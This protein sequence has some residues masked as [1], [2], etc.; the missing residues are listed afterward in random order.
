MKD[1]V[2]LSAMSLMKYHFA[3]KECPVKDVANNYITLRLIV[4]KN[5]YGVIDKY[6]GLEELSYPF[7]GSM[8]QEIKTRSKR[9]L[10]YICAALNSIFIDRIP[11]NDASSIARVSYE[12]I[13][14]FFDNYRA[15]KNQNNDFRGQD[16]LEKCVK[17]VS[18]FFGNAALAAGTLAAFDPKKLFIESFEKKT[19]D[20]KR[21]ILKYKPIYQKESLQIIKRKIPRDV[22]LDA[23]S[24]LWDVCREHCPEIYFT[25]VAQ[26]T[27]GLRPGEAVNLRRE[28]SPL[29]RGL[30]MTMYGTSISNIDIFIEKEMP[31]RSDGIRVGGIKKKRIQQ[32]YPPFIYMFRDAYQFHQYYL[33]SRKYEADYSP[34]FINKNGKALTYSAYKAKFQK[35]VAEHL[36][37]R[38]MEAECPK[39][40]ALGITLG[41][42]KLSPHALRHFFTVALVLAGEEAAQIQYFRGDDS[43]D[44][45]YL[46]LKNKGELVKEAENAQSEVFRD[47]L[48]LGK[49]IY[50]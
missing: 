24:M 19:K 39:L 35:L 45:A 18:D 42:Q 13:M 23:M 38:L 26:C 5:K 47:L 2:N 15:K 36:R 10:Q 31:L 28:D 32:V 11:C 20:S 4:I 30:S 49:R 25:V 6:T 14:E 37:P 17:A 22:P 40:Q 9:E 1:I 46:Y 29:G 7:S 50:A 21:V 27:A 3:V 33:Q 48:E 8:E 43:P 12:T 16:S 44:S 41:Q 34:M